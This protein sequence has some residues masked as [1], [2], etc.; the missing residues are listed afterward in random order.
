[1]SGGSAR[2]RSILPLRDQPTALVRQ[3]IVFRDRLLD[4]RFGSGR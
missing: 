1:M 3:G 2:D 4:C